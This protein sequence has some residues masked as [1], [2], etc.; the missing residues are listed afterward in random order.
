MLT[1]DASLTP[2]ATAYIDDGLSHGLAD[3]MA[4]RA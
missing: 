1:G 2:I 3:G 4:G